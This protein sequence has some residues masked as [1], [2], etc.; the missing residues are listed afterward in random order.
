MIP[1]KVTA[2]L[3]TGQ[4][5]T[6][7]GDLPLDGPLAW[8]WMMRHHPDALLNGDPRADAPIEPDLP[9]AKRIPDHDPAAWYWA[10]SC[11][12]YA[13]GKEYVKHWHKRFDDEHERSLDLQ[14]KS[15]KIREGSGLLK[16]YRIPL[17]VLTVTE[18]VWHC[19]GDKDG[20]EDLTGDLTAMGKKTSQ[21]YGQIAEWRIEPWPADW[22][23]YDGAGRRTRA[24]PVPS[25]QAQGIRGIRPPYWLAANQFPCLLREA[26]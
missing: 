14:G 10:C 9:L 4:I 3:F 1:L 23:E 8:A 17:I 2:V 15:G 5:V 12:Q 11:A 19:V 20:I 18:L 13:A 26:G 24:I 22:S 21:G 7:D 16:A 6:Y 25:E